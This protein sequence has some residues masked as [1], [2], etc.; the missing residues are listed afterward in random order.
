LKETNL[1]SNSSTL[2]SLEVLGALFTCLSLIY[3]HVRVVI[4]KIMYIRC[5]KHNR[6]PVSNT[7]VMVIV[8]VMIPRF[9]TD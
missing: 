4:I 3:K 8:T 9:L 2:M 1:N 7:I 6:F 5:L